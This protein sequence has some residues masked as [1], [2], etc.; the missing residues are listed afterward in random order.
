MVTSSED[1]NYLAHCRVWSQNIDLTVWELLG[2]KLVNRTIPMVFLVYGLSICSRRV[3]L[4]RSHLEI[5]K[6]WFRSKAKFGS[7]EIWWRIQLTD[8]S[9]YIL[10]CSLPKKYSCL[11]GPDLSCH[12]L[13]LLLSS[14]P[15]DDSFAWSIIM[16]SAV[17]A[18]NHS[19]TLTHNH[20]IP[21]SVI[22]H[23][24]HELWIPLL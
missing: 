12:Q 21:L 2:I 14:T 1:I 23:L 4:R 17:K 11:I 19:S 7:K 5:S 9:L 10:G 16:P 22:T 15:L 6:S 24:S 20:I 3:I 13:V 8:L 18:H